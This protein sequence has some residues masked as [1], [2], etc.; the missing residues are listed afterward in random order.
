MR[1][2]RSTERARI[3]ERGVVL[4]EFA[5]VLPL[6]LTLVLG[7]MD[8]GRALNYWIY[9]THLSNEAARY[10]V[11]NTWPGCP[12]ATAGTCD[13]SS[14]TKKKLQTFIKEQV[15]TKELTGANGT[16]VCVF[17]PDG[18]IAGG[19]VE[20]QVFYKFK[21]LGF[22]TGFGTSKIGNSAT[23]RLEVAPTHLIADPASCTT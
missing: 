19:R 1:P 14:A 2:L 5:F 6:L 17:L 20:V 8:F 11:V 23:M 13:D 10:A 15:L 21:W 9:Q 3:G 18:A 4:V 22:F 16:K 12:V 7:I